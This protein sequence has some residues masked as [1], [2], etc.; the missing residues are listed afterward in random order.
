MPQSNPEFPDYSETP[1]SAPNWARYLTALVAV[2]L[3]IS[4]FAWRHN[5]GMRQDTWI[6]GAL[7][8]VTALVAMAIP[9]FRWVNTALAVW[10]FLST[11]F[12][13][14]QSAGT[15]WNNVIVAGVVFVLSLFPSGRLVPRPR[16]V[17]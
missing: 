7:M 6:V 8:F 1:N 17:H 16:V 9:A 3:F 13:P 10:L 15:I 5:P 11:L 4:A 12:L 14:H 2:W